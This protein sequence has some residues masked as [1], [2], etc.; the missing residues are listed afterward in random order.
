RPPRA[1]A[2]NLANCSEGLGTDGCG[3]SPIGNQD[4]IPVQGCSPAPEESL[5]CRPRNGRGLGDVWCSA[6]ASQGSLPAWHERR[7]QRRYARV[8]TYLFQS[9]SLLLTG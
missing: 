9:V 3:C 6:R 2:P 8:W 1:G 7:E 5:V 4:L